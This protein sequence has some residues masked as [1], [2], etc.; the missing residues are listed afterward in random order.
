MGN[1][2]LSFY[3]ENEN[4][5]KVQ[6]TDFNVITIQINDGDVGNRNCAE[7]SIDVCT[8][9]KFCKELRKQIGEAKENIQKMEN[10]GWLD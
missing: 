9:V 3:D 8:A 4:C 7:I 10:N 2:R 6:N 1:I 5:L